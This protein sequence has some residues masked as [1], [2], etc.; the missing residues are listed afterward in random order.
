MVGTACR[1]PQADTPEAFWE[2]LR[3][4][5]DAVTGLPDGRPD[6]H[7]PGEAPGRARSGA[8]LDHVDLFDPAFFGIG[9]REAAAMDPQQR[10]VLEL[11]WEALERTGIVPASLAGTRTGVFVGAMADDYARLTQQLGPAAVGQHTATGLHRGII[12]NRVSY[13]LGLTG[14]SMS[15]DTGQSSSLTAVH[16]A[17]E[18]LLRGEAD[19]AIAGGVSLNL[20][21]D[22]YEITEAFGAL[23]PDG[24]CHTFDARANGYVRGEGGGLVLLKRLSDALDDG[25]RVL[26]VILGSAVNNDGTTDT[27]TTP[28]ARGQ[29]DLLRL[30]CDRAG[31]AP[32]DIQY[33]ELHGTGTR[34]GDPVEATALGEAL[35]A[36]RGDGARLRVGSAKTNVGHLEGA[37]GITGLIKT[38]LSLHHRELP[39]SLHFRSANPAIPLADL[40]LRVQEEHG[41]WPDGDRRLIAGVSSFGMGGAN[42][43]VVVAEP[44]SQSPEEEEEAD[45]AAVAADGK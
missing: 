10:L 4:G 29:T 11:A 8:F 2:L 19:L 18:S 13:L 43:H 21:A 25:D 12:A 44:P 28:G 26:G 41:P 14:P 15:V 24:R 39:R 32:G 40:G 6:L 22:G 33:V 37:A 45:R 17:C 42:A 7:A 36:G 16:L 31:V 20:T 34:L 30:A 23:S 35:G 9:P 3:D 38:L 5:R 1:L 27:L